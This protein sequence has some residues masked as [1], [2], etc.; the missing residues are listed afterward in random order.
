[1]YCTLP[2]HPHVPGLHT[3]T[4]E[5]GQGRQSESKERLNVA[6]QQM[7]PPSADEEVD[8]VKSLTKS[9]HKYKRE[10]VKHLSF[11]P[12]NESLSEC[13]SNSY[14]LFFFSATMLDHAPLEAVYIYFSTATFDQILR[15][16]KVTSLTLQLSMSLKEI[17]IILSCGYW[18]LI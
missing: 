11:N 8:E 10:Y 3:L 15:D 4:Q 2:F 14:L 16:E 18:C 1:M 13:V 7:F 12:E 9:Y 6:L 17:E 5:L